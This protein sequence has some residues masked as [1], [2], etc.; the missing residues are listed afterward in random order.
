MKKLSILIL[1]LVL[2]LALAVP[3][4][5]AQITLDETATISGMSRSWYQG[6]TP[7][8]RSNM[9]T[10]CL[11]LRGEGLDGSITAS[12][13]LDDPD[14][15][16]F[17]S[18]PWT[19]TAAPQN[20]LYPVRLG[21]PLERY[22]RN[23]DFPATITVKGTDTAGNP[24]EEALPYVIRIRDGYTSL[25]TLQPVIS[26]AAAE[27][28]VGTEGTLT[29]TLTNPTTTISMEAP[30]LTVTDPSGEI[31]MSGSDRLALP[32]LLPGKSQTVTV[33]LTVKTTAAIAPHSLQL[34]LSYQALSKEETWEETFTLPV[35][36]TVRLE[37]GGI[38][39][40]DAIAGELSSMT[41]P[42]MNM[43]KGELSNVLVK[44]QMEGVLDDQS[45]LVGTM[46]PGETKQAKLT[47]T[48]K[49][50]STGTHAGTVTVTCEDAYG[51]LYTQTLDTT[52]LVDEPLPEPEEVQAAEKKSTDLRLILLLLL[53]VALTAGIILQGVLL[54][55]KLHKLEEERL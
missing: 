35:T 3:G 43:G 55:G 1:S 11:P 38:Q 28:N 26:D 46:A 10:L 15:F 31:L 36:Q 49:L 33:P 41:L 51:N 42:L 27:L 7:T 52:L 21:L 4:Q 23:G 19:V 39:M 8:V 53:C 2:L 48:P 25:E 40:T 50:T 18:P 34:S 44:L 16:L 22:R 30:V 29:F 13:A 32:E 37:Q 9:M 6:Y 24:V 5:A 54:T 47:F 12:I 45:V 17:S 20:G 14:L